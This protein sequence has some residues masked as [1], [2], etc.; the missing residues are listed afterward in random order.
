MVD[1]LQRDFQLVELVV[2][3]FV[4]ARCL[5]GGPDK[6]AAEQVTQARV[7]VPVQQQAG[8]QLGPPQERAIG[9][10][11]TAHHKVVAAASP[12]VTTIGHELFGRQ[13]RFK[14]RLVQEFGV[15]YQFA[16][17][18]DRVDVDFDHARVRG[19]L[20]QFQ[21]RVT[22]RR[23]T[24]QHQLH[25]LFLRCRL[26]G[27]QQVQVVLQFFQRRHEHIQ[28]AR[29]LAHGFGLRT[30]GAARVAYLDA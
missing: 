8:E 6:H 17:V 2:A 29:R 21:A 20:Q 22:R 1:L 4:H 30:A 15:F 27:C 25:A 16:P 26:D 9:R 23:V 12:R 3:G 7:V 14:R 28:H 10:A 11:G 18:A 5:A 24:F 19:D 13:A